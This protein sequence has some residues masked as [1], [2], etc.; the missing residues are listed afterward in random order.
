VKAKAPYPLASTVVMVRPAAFGF[1]R[2]TAASNAFQKAPAGLDPCRL[3]A[4]A[5][6]EFDRAVAM[7][8]AEGVNVLV[9][10]D[11]ALPRKPD[12][13]FP[14][15]WFGTLPT[16]ALYTFPLLSPARRAERRDDILSYLA[17][18]HGYG[19]D[20]SLLT[21]EGEGKA[22]EGTGSLVFDHGARLA[23]AAL[24]PRTDEGALKRFEALSGYR[25]VPFRTEGPGG[26]PVYHTNVVM[27]VGPAFAV[28]GAECIHP[29]DRAYVLGVLA[30]AG[31]AVLKLTNQQ[32]FDAFA[33]N[34][35]ALKGKGDKPLLVMSA[36]ARA[37]LTNAQVKTLLDDFGCRITAIPIPTIEK[38]GGGSVRCLLAE[39]L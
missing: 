31:K 19:L 22:L 2:E 39:V 20:Q 13:V 16:G 34:M 27:T 10:E 23:F 12:A 5:L 1:N 26:K 18:T 17:R 29:K 33:G 8:E 7:L 32:V 25:V 3:Q 38:V 21:F 9:F 4:E 28:V 11:T 36:A 24:S 30:R 37:A 14:N 6:A 15:N 35:L